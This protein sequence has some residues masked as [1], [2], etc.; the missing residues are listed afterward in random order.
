MFH[1]SKGNT[2]LALKYLREASDESKHDPEIEKQFA[3]AIVAKRRERQPDEILDDMIK[4][5]ETQAWTGRPRPRE[6]QDN[7]TLFRDEYMW[8]L[9]KNYPI[10][11]IEASLEE[12]KT[13]HQATTRNNMFNEWSYE[14]AISENEIYEAECQG[15]VNPEN[16]VYEIEGDINHV[17][18]AI[19]HELSVEASR[20]SKDDTAEE[21]KVITGP[22]GPQKKSRMFSKLSH[23]FK[24][25]DRME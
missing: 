23:R 18:R 4:Y 6:I 3:M 2:D 24:H 5:K 13:Q 21:T 22:N 17:A 14:K 19:S 25:H 8:I 20:S 12:M 9:D 11:E 15:L 10:E 1:L 16:E 7:N